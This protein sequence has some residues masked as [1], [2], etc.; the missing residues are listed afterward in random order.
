M[1]M[2]IAFLLIL[3]SVPSYAAL[4]V[5]GIAMGFALGG[6]LPLWGALIG[7]CYGPKRSAQ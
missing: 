3:L 7:D 4:V 2:L 1:L 6:A 5:G